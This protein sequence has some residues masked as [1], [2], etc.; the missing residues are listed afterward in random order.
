MTHNEFRQMTAFARIDGLL[1]GLLWICSFY[2]LIKGFTSSSSELIGLIITFASPFYAAKRL[3]KFRDNALN[4]TITFKRALAY[5]MLEYF[6]A[7]IILAAAV[8][9]YFSLLDH[10]YVYSTLERIYTDPSMQPVLKSLSMTSDD[11]LSIYS[12]Y[13]PVDFAFGTI[14]NILIIGLFISIPTALLKQRNN[15]GAKTA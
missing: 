5:S 12:H 9:I 8:F 6:Y 1:I 3:G 2:F 11:I 13:R 10:G 7:S 15:T 4:G 14:S